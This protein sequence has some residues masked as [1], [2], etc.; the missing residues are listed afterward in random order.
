MTAA[1]RWSTRRTPRR[2]SFGP[3]V[4][5]V[6]RALGHPPMEWQAL[7]L[8][9]G[10]EHRVKGDRPYFDEA[11]VVT[12]PRQ[13]GKT[14]GIARPLM[15]WR[16]RKW[17]DQNI[18]Y[19]AETRQKAAKRLIVF[20]NQL[21]RYGWDVKVTRGIG[22]ERIE[23]PNASSIEVV[24]P[25]EVAGH[26]ESIDLAVLDEAWT[27]T[28]D[29][30]QGIVPARAARPASMLWFLST[31]GNEDSTVLNELCE[32]GRAAVVDKAARL[33]YFEWSADEA[34]GDEVHNATHWG[35]WM[36]ALEHTVTVANVEAAQAVLSNEAFR[37]AFGNLLTEGD[38]DLM[39]GDWWSDTFN[40][41]ETPT[42]GRVTYAFDVN[43]EPPGAAIAAAYPTD[44]DGWHVD[45]VAYEPGSSTLWIPPQLEKLVTASHPLA[46]G[47]A[48]GGPARSILPTV[49]EY[50]E[51]RTIPLRELTVQD[52]AAA[53]G[54]L[55]DGI[56][57]KVLQHGESRALDAAIGA[58]RSKQVAD[59]W[60][61]D[62][63]RSRVDVSPLIAATVA[64][65]VAQE[66]D[67]KRRVPAIY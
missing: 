52:M 32:Q 39:P 53:T 62:R 41:Y 8:D 64:L 6:S 33:A 5:D 45:I 65:F 49:R 56:R 35:R 23:F 55:Y 66:A 24:A 14:T 13:Q 38:D 19:T 29:L 10:L 15:A 11:V 54:L 30:L 43:V 50:C 57:D 60:R 20:G 40:P 61:I 27:A 21:I 48:G 1:P 18:I 42:P 26:G 58:A 9:V 59:L 51:Q 17:P 47:T 63:R 37:R 3:E 44:G 2:R 28:D 25:N 31:Q 16:A 36:P 67:A 22:N 12:V 7:V 34:A 46:I 4:A